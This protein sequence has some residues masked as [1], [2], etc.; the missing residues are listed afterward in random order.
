MPKSRR[1]FEIALS[2]VPAVAGLLTAVASALVAS[3]SLLSADNLLRLKEFFLNPV[4]A[5]VSVVYATAIAAILSYAMLLIV[6]STETRSSR[7]TLEPQAEA[8][9]PMPLERDEEPRLSVAEQAALEKQRNQSRI[10]V[11]FTRTR[12]RMLEETDR[13]QRNGLLNLMI[14]ILFSGIALGILGYPLFVPNGP[15]TS[16]WIGLLERFA[17]RFSVGILVQLIG[18][19]F[20]RLYVAGENE[21]HYLRNELT[22][23]EATVPPSIES[24]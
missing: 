16:E 21:V 11:A 10:R 19:F 13:I 3:K 14:G 6:R 1:K 7:R 2:V 24:V 5:A 4:S 22:N 20:L 15:Q 8:P 18:F 12:R 23:W 17:P 9:E